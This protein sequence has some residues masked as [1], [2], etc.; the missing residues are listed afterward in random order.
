M[1]LWLELKEY[2]VKVVKLI[3]FG[4]FCELEPGLIRLCH[5]SEMDWARK[6]E[7]IARSTFHCNMI[8]HYKDFESVKSIPNVKE[9]RL[10]TV[11]EN[12]LKG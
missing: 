5:S 2:E 1:R 8:M 3:D 12:E 4:A 10:Q 11:Y 7:K 6:N 9:I